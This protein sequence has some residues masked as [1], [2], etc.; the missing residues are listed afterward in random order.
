MVYRDYWAL[1][2]WYAHYS[3]HLG[4]DNLFIVA[5]GRD[6]RI[7]ELC[8]RANVMSVPRDDLTGFDRMRGHML[9]SIQDGLGVAYDWVI[10]TDVDELICVDPSHYS[11]LE[12]VFRQY[13]RVSSLFALGMN[14]VDAADDVELEQSDAVLTKR[15]HVVFSGH[16]SKAFAV[17]RGVHMLR[18]GIKHTANASFTL[19]QG[20]Y[21]LHLKYANTDALQISNEHRAAIA[22]GAQPGLPG[23]AWSEADLDAERFYKRFENLPQ[24]A[25]NEALGT[26]YTQ[27]AA[28]PET[29]KDK[30]VLRAKSIKFDCRTVLPNWFKYC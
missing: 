29:E 10:R 3:R 17:K 18:H 14:V 2:Q 6:E 20:V 11:S 22:S 7:S 28:M 12:D 5:H 4:S 26:A 9:N 1:S 15:R 19:P 13:N 27:I 21:L 8:P 16:Y 24:V 23:T 25:W 30:G